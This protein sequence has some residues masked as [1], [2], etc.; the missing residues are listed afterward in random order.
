MPCHGQSIEANDP[1]S[2]CLDT[3]CEV[4]STFLPPLWHVG[5][6]LELRVCQVLDDISESDAVA[7]QTP[8]LIGAKPDSKR[9][10]QN[11]LPGLA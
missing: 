11:E 8:S 6:S 7:G 9:S 1:W 2:G 3:L 4:G 5:F 10:S